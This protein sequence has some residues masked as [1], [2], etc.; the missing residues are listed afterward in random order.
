[1]EQTTTLFTDAFAPGSLRERVMRIATEQPGVLR[2]SNSDGPTTV[3]TL[4][5][6]QQALGDELLAAY[7]PEVRVRL[8]NFDYPLDASTATDVCPAVDEWPH[9]TDELDA[10][11]ILANGTVAPGAD[12]TGT[13]TVTNVGTR[14]VVLGPGPYTP[15][16]RNR[17]THDVVGMEVEAAAGGSD[18]VFPLQP[19]ESQTFDITGTTAS[20]DPSLGA[21]LPPGTYE[22]TVDLM[23]PELSAPTA[24]TQLAAGPAPL[25]ISAG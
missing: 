3:V 2:S 4:R 16:V 9:A 6:D 7:G 15:V 13:L 18:M 19:G 25:R 11:L 23:G 21:A 12:F 20:C 8:G 17:E 22:V 14:Q 10:T 24:A 1:M 5:A